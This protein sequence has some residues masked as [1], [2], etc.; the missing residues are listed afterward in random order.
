MQKLLFLQITMLF[1]HER[2]VWIV[3]VIDDERHTAV[4]AMAERQTDRQRD[5]QRD[6][7]R[8]VKLVSYD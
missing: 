2:D 5:R 6:S 4:G 3:L 8:R 7:E 1:S